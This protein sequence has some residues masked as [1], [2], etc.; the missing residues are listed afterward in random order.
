M[1]QQTLIL[2]C[3]LQEFIFLINKMRLVGFLGIKNES[4][5]VGKSIFFAYAI[6]S[7]NDFLWSCKVIGSFP[8]YIRVFIMDN[9]LNDI[10]DKILSNLVTALWL[11]L[12]CDWLCMYICILIFN[13]LYSSFRLL[14]GNFS[15]V[16]FGIY[17]I[18]NS[19]WIDV[20]IREYFIID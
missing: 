18:D 13:L 10:E 2:W 7:L 12:L 8:F 6:I 20:I 11:F 16:D 5:F 4:I 3:L 1:V 15:H 17:N 9:I 19:I 14:P